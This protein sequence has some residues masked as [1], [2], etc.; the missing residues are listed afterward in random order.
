MLPSWIEEGE[1]QD[2]GRIHRGHWSSSKGSYSATPSRK[3]ADIGVNPSQVGAAGRHTKILKLFQPVRD[4]K[5]DI[6]E[7]EVPEEAATN[8]TLKLREAKVL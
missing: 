4:G 1:R 7:G 3:P 2:F 5:C 6:I 8:L